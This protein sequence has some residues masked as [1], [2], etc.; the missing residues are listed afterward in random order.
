MS[1]MLP[2]KAKWNTTVAGTTH[3]GDM[4][5]SVKT[6]P[7]IVDG[8]KFTLTIVWSGTPTG[9]VTIYTSGNWDTSQA[10]LTADNWNGTWNSINSLLDPAITQPAGAGGSYE[11]SS[12][13]FVGKYMYVDYARSAGSGSITVDYSAASDY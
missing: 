2:G 9:T 6:K 3:T 12:G 11:L 4:A 5:G 8:K 7:F 13:T 1:M 10:A